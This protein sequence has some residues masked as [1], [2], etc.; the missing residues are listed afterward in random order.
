ML[1]KLKGLNF[2]KRLSAKKNPGT[3]ALES[4][5][6]APPEP[7][8]DDDAAALFFSL[9]LPTKLTFTAIFPN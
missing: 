5:Q 1:K 3:W 2:W 4:F 7:N 8:D 6:L 9:W